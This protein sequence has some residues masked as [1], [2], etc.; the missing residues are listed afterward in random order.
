MAAPCP[1]RFPKRNIW[2]LNRL[3]QKKNQAENAN[4]LSSEL[5]RTIPSAMFWS[6]LVTIVALP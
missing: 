4:F 1:N 6:S 3:T 5:Q 2:T